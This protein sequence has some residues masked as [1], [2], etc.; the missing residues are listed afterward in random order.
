MTAPNQPLAQ[1]N[2]PEPGEVRD[3]GFYNIQDGQKGR[4]GGP[5]LD[6]VL[7]GEAELLRARAEGREP[8]D[9]EGKLPASVG[10][11]LVIARLVP[12]NSLTSN[13]S[14]APRAGLEQA[15]SD[16]T[17]T[18]ND[19]VADPISV[20]PVQFAGQPEEQDDAPPSDSVTESNEGTGPESDQGSAESETSVS[21]KQ[22]YGDTTTADEDN[23]F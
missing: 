7:R 14:M 20:L 10:T 22:Q 21:D 1:D 3:V 13:P 18:E 2:A 15:F 12:D 8:D 5:Y 9:L 17:F 23:T 6:H 19:Q 16:E 11:Q 4:D